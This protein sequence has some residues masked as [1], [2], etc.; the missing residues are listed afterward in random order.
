MAQLLA[1][2]AWVQVPSPLHVSV[3]HASPSS[4]L[5]VVPL[6]VPLRQ[7]SLTVHAFPSLHE[8]PSVFVGFEHTPVVGS[9]TPAAWHWSCA[10]QEIGVPALHLPAP[11]QV[12]APLQGLP[13]LQLVPEASAG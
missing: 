8:V 9:H 10:V 5:Y 1:A 3:V 13:S 7:M 4:Q 2:M 11:S 12:S 6:H